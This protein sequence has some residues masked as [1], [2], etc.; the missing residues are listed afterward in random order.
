MSNILNDWFVIDNINSF[1]PT[2]TKRC[3]R[4]GCVLRIVNQSENLT[5]F[6]DSI[7][8]K[9][10]RIVHIDNTYESLWTCIDGVIV[11]IEVLD[12]KP[13]VTLAN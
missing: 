10:L 8:S 2:A 11:D 1:L 5:P 9:I 4:C 7:L 3:N 12:N 6:S 13:C